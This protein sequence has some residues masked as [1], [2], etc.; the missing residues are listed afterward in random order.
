MILYLQDLSFK[1]VFYIG[2]HQAKFKPVA[3]NYG[4]H[5]I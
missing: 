2:A 1:K 4:K 5:F 3:K